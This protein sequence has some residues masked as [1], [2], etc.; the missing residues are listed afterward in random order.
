MDNSKNETCK[1]LE[2]CFEV[3]TNR[4]EDE[5]MEEDLIE[6]EKLGAEKDDSKNHSDQVE[7][8][9]TI[10]QLIDKNSPWRRTKKK[11]LNEP[12]PEL[13]DY[14][15]PPYPIIKKKPLQE[16]DTRLFSRFNEMLT[17]LEVSIY[18]H[19][20]LELIP[21]FSKF[22]KAFLNGTK[23]KLDKE[24]V[25]MVEKCDTVVPETITPKMKDPCKFTIMCTIWRVNISHALFDWG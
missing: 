14:I 12:N 25:N 17:K 1:D 16:D 22:M 2:T 5:I 6:E 8:E 18:F 9:F 21:K 13:S 10:G 15:K 7:K 24:Q 20:V 19:E 4:G 3:I 11:I 23:Q